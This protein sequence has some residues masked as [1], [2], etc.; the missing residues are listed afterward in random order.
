MC[1]CL[2]HLQWRCFKIL[3]FSQPIDKKAPDFVFFAP[4]LRINK[5]ILTLCMGNHELY[6]RRRKPDT[7]EVKNLARHKVNLSNSFH[8]KVQFLG[9]TDEGSE[10]GGEAGEA[11]GEGEVAARDRCQG[12]G[13]EVA[14]K[15]FKSPMELVKIEM[16]LTLQLSFRRSMRRGSGQCSRRWSAGKRSSPL[17]KAQSGTSNYPNSQRKLGRGGQN[18]DLGFNNCV[19]LQETWGAAEG[20]AGGEGWAGRATAGAARDDDQVE[21]WFSFGQLTQTNENMLRLE[22][23]K[24]MEA[25]ERARL[26]EEINS[27]RSEV[28][29]NSSSLLPPLVKDILEICLLISCSTLKISLRY[30]CW[31]L[32]SSAIQVEDI[33]TEVQRK[34]EENRQLQEEMDAARQR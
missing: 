2:Y 29:P 25:E 14:G 32:I 11:A 23:S 8:R 28:I 22:E 3:P 4:R 21:D 16:C 19:V 9:A 10:Q 26:E 17:P 5:R 31:V 27:K 33:L 20:D 18:Q 34:E 12:E 13:R 30:G 7:I 1:A 15:L 24:T 6:M